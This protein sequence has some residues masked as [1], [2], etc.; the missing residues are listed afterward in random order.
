MS[1]YKDKQIEVEE[2]RRLL[3]KEQKEILQAY[4]DEEKERV[5]REAN[6]YSYALK[7]CNLNS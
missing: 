7:Q 3:F 2:T 4:R 5:Q 1:I 6:A